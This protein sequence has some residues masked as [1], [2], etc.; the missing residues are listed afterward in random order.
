M[1]IGDYVKMKSLFTNGDLYYGTITHING[2]YILVDITISGQVV[3][4]ER[5]ENE[6]EVL[7]K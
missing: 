5:Y 2:A 3:S 6:L 4:V 1:K 7:T